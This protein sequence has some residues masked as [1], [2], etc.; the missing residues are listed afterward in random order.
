MAT[1][2]EKCAR[3]GLGEAGHYREDG[4][5]VLRCLPGRDGRYKGFLYEPRLPPAETPSA[6]PEGKSEPQVAAIPYDEHE[7]QMLQVIDERDAAEEALSQAYYLIMGRSA[8]WSN[9]FGHAEALQDIDD[10]QRTMRTAITTPV[11]AGKPQD[12]PKRP[13]VTGFAARPFSYGQQA[14][15]YIDFLEAEINR[16]KGLPLG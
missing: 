16:L 3:C 13:D 11:V 14:E 7:R 5:R 4:E 1:I 9:L 8:E 12:E 2:E 6:P 10:A 15:A